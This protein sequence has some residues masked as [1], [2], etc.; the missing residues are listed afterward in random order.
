MTKQFSIE[1]SDSTHDGGTKFYAIWTVY[2]IRR[3]VTVF[4]WGKESVHDAGFCKSGEVTVDGHPSYDSAD[5]N[6]RAQ[7]KAKGK[8][9]YTVWTKPARNCSFGTGDALKEEIFARFGTNTGTRILEALGEEL[10][11]AVD[12][13]DEAVPIT[14]KEP[15]GPA[16]DGWGTW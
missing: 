5:I 3:A 8:R 9:E 6:A 10:D 15:A 13:D 2:G 4:N 11:G 16:V 1:C 7:Q 12:P 14:T